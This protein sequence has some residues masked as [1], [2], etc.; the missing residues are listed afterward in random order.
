MEGDNISWYL[1][2]ENITV[3]LCPVAYSDHM[4]G[5][6]DATSIEVYTARGGKN[7]FVVGWC[8][9]LLVCGILVPQTIGL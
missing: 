4:K 1:S 6:A 3:A 8:P 9:K 7:W 2:C 5:M